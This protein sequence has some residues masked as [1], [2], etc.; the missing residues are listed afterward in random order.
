MW[1]NIV[2]GDITDFDVEVIVNAANSSLLGGGGGVDGAIHR[3]AGP[4]L[5]EECKKI[6]KDKYLAGL[7]TGQ[8][9]LTKGYNLPA[10][11]IIHTV[12]PIY[13]EEDILL[14][15]NCYRN[16]LILAE[17]NYFKRIAFPCISTGVYK[18]PKQEAA[19]LVKEVI[20]E[21]DFHK[22]EEVHFVMFDN[23]SYEIYK[24]LFN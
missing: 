13:G 7:P 21:F 16:A 15:K 4:K 23:E 12:G 3:K 14:L 1:I 8:V 22:I 5:L 11:N 2:K 20:D 6:R 24:E 18:V 9:V 10:K 17:E 19:Q